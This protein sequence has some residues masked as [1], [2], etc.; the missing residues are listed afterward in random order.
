MPR[1]SGRNG[2]L[3]CR[4]WHGQAHQVV[5]GTERSL[6]AIARRDHDLL[7]GHRRHV[8]G[9][10]H[11]RHRGAAIS[12]HHDLAMAAEFQRTLEPLVVGHQADLLHESGSQ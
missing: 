10:E 5:E 3:G 4:R 11:A 2:L 12:I 9:R 8:A 7:E 1:R 6:R